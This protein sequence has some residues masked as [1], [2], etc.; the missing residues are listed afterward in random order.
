VWTAGNH[1][2]Y[3]FPSRWAAD[4]PAK[5]RCALMMVLTLRGAAFLYYGDE[6]GM[7]DTE[8]PQAR[9]RDPVGIKFYP[10]FGR[11]PERTPMHWSPKSGGG[12]SIDPGAEPW[13][14][15]GD[16]AT[17]NVEDQRRDPHSMLSL[18][19]DLIGLREAV[20]D[21]RQ[22]E[23]ETL[24]A[25]GGLWAWSRGDR[26]VVALNLADEPTTLDSIEGMVRIG[27]RRER[28]GERVDGRLELGGWEAAVVWLDGEPRSTPM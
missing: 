26:V 20:P 2:V 7:P 19:R 17:C 14:P 9:L 15:Y 8:I 24:V 25:N 21:L 22:G 27:T 3:R 23:Y 18:C 1:D 12:F 28:D 5:A 6:I 10:A 4:D 16:S 11:D 13:L